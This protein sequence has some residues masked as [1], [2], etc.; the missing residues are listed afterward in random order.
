[1]ESLLGYMISFETWKKYIR[2]STGSDDM[3]SRVISFVVLL[4]NK[5][6]F[7]DSLKLGLS[8]GEF[9]ETLSY[10]ELIDFEKTILL[11]RNLNNVPIVQIGS[12]KI[13]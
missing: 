1:M 5:P 9:I 3:K 10:E 4:F 6:E 11:A 12:E 7:L 13:N 8:F 2:L